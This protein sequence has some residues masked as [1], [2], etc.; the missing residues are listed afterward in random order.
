MYK[1]EPRLRRIF[2]MPAPPRRR[3]SMTTN[4]A[5]VGIL[6]ATGYTGAELLRLLARH[7][8]ARV[9]CMTSERF[10]GQTIDRVFPHLAGR[11]LP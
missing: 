4:S 11:D 5:S 7:G 10:A 3:S 2:H 9:T 6:G 8:S 1:Q